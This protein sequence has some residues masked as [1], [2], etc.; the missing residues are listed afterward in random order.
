MENLLLLLREALRTNDFSAWNA[1]VGAAQPV[2]ASTVF[3]CLS[4]WRRPGA[5]E[6]EDLV[7]ETF[8]RMCANNLALLRQFRGD[9]PEGLTALLRTVAS[10]AVW[11][12]WRSQGA[13]KRGGDAEMVPLEEVGGSLASSA[14]VERIEQDLLLKQVRVCLSGRPEREQQIFWLYFRHGL[15]SE[16]ISRIRC[17]GLSSKGVQSLLH[18]LTSV[19]REC[20]EQKKN[21]AA[22]EG[23]AARTSLS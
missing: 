8:L 20:L 23:K 16:A 18:R 1:F 14:S 3:T 10:N 11:D 17:V 12:Y 2:V 9:R 13:Q 7:Q 19:V 21:L 4:K 6:V 22:N 5:E 15:T